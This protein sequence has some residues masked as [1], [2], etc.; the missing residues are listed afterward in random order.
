[1]HNFRS[2][3]GP[4]CSKSKVVLAHFASDSKVVLARFVT[5]ACPNLAKLDEAEPASSKTLANSQIGCGW[6]GERWEVERWSL[7]EFQNGRSQSE[8]DEVFP[9]LAWCFFSKHSRGNC[10]V[11]REA[12]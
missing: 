8:R 10:G 2:G 5:T 3:P 12:V 6:R 7:W 9:K 4:L 11:F 1:M